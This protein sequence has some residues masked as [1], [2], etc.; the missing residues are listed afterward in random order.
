M[1][2]GIFA[3][4]LALL[5]ASSASASDQ[6][7]TR[8]TLRPVGAVSAMSKDGGPPARQ[9]GETPA[10][11]LEPVEGMELLIARIGP[12]GKPVLAC[13]DSAAAAKRFLEA[14]IETVATKAKEK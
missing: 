11:L 12:D 3:P 6:S 4:A 9:V 5:I 13:V 10:V 1:Q 8:D 2:R 7:C 14:P